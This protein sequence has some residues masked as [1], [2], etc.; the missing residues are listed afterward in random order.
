MPATIYVKD[1]RNSE[2][3]LLVCGALPTKLKKRKVRTLVVAITAQG[4]LL[5]W[6]CGWTSNLL[7]P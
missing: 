3:V 1:A 7:P 4:L 2:L 6:K 5:A